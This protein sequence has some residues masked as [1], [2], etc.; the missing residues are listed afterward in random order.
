M[1]FIKIR[2]H[3]LNHV[4]MCGDLHSRINPH[5]SSI[6]TDSNPATCL[7]RRVC[8]EQR[9]TQI[10]RLSSEAAD[11]LLRNRLGHFPSHVVPFIDI[12]FKS[13]WHVKRYR[14][15]RTQLGLQ[16]AEQQQIIESFFIIF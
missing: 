13:Q 16:S 15:L 5:T 4:K 6:H 1:T 14:K 11:T 8:V 7:I 9:F 10:R 3:G 12:Q 2:H